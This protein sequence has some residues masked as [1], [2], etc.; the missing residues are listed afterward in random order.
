MAKGRDSKG[1]FLK[2]GN[3]GGGKR[4]RKSKAL[5]RQG[6]RSPTRRRS[7]GGRALRRRSSGGRGGLLSGGVLKYVGSPR[8]DDMVASA[9]L[10]W[11]VGG[12]GSVLTL[13]TGD[14]RDKAR[15]ALNM[16]VSKAP[17]PLAQLGGYA[18]LS[19]AS[20]VA[21]H[22]GFAP[23]Y[24]RPLA[25]VSATMAAFQLGRRGI[26][27]A[28]QVDSSDAFALSGDDDGGDWTAG[29]DDD[30]DA[31]GDDYADDSAGTLPVEDG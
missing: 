23:R 18:V 10:G 28:D 21:A 11:A 2:R 7:S 29:D 19:I 22:Y 9:A 1:R 27:E 31:A 16:L 12:K 8:T 14:M 26:L 3:S 20:G 30:D 5:T 4:R 24:L 15:A 25:R 17:G 13:A 6:T